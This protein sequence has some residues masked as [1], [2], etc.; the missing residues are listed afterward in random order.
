MQRELEQQQERLRE[1]QEVNKRQSVVSKEQH[2]TLCKLEQEIGQ[3]QAASQQQH[4]RLCEL[5]E[6]IAG[7][8]LASEPQQG[9]LL[10]LEEENRQQRVMIA[11]QQRASKPK[12]HQ[13]QQVTGAVRK[14]LGPVT[15]AQQGAR[16]RKGGVWGCTQSSLVLSTGACQSQT[17]MTATDSGSGG[18]S[19]QTKAV[20]RSVGEALTARDAGGGDGDCSGDDCSIYEL[21]ADEA[22]ISRG[23]MEGKSNDHE[24]S[25]N[26]ADDGSSSGPDASDSTYVCSNNGEH[27]E[28]SCDERLVA[29]GSSDAV[30]DASDSDGSSNCRPARKAARIAALGVQLRRG[31]GRKGKGRAKR[32]RPKQQRKLCPHG[33]HHYYCND[34]GGAGICEHGRRHRTCKDCVGSGICEHR[35]ER[36]YC[37]DC[38][39]IT[40]AAL[41]AGFAFE[42][43]ND[44][45]VYWKGS[46][47]ASGKGMAFLSPRFV[48]DTF[49]GELTAT[50]LHVENRHKPG[51]PLGFKASAAVV[52]EDDWLST[53]AETDDDWLSTGAQTDVKAA[54]SR[55]RAIWKEDFA[56]PV[57]DAAAARVRVTLR[58]VNWLPDFTGRK[59]IATLTLP[60]REVLPGVAGRDGGSGANGLHSTGDGSKLS[61]DGNG[62][63]GGGGSGCGAAATADGRDAALGGSD[64]GDGG[65][66]EGRL[67]QWAGWVDFETVPPRRGRSSYRA[68]VQLVYV[69]AAARVACAPALGGGPRGSTPGMDWRMVAHQVARLP[70]ARAMEP[71]ALITDESTNAQCVVWHD[72][73]RRRLVAA[74]RGTAYLADAVTDAAFVQVPLSADVVPR[75]AAWARFAAALARSRL[76]AA[77]D[78]LRSQRAALRALGTGPTSAARRAYI[79]LGDV[80]KAAAA[81]L[82]AL[83]AAADKAAAAAATTAAAEAGDAAGEGA[84]AVAA[85]AGPRGDGGAS[86]GSGD[87]GADGGGD[88]HDEAPP[89]PP[90][91]VEEAE[92]QLAASTNADSAAVIH[93]GALA[94]PPVDP[95]RPPPPSSTVLNV[96]G[97]AVR[98][99]AGLTQNAL[100]S[101]GGALLNAS[102][103]SPSGVGG[104]SGGARSGGGGGG[105]G[106][107]S[108]GGRWGGVKDDSPE[109]RATRLR[110]ALLEV[111]DVA[112]LSD[113]LLVH[114]GFHKSYMGI[115]AALADVLATVLRGSG[116]DVTEATH[117]YF[118]GHSLGGALATLAALDAARNG[119]RGRA[120]KGITRAMRSTPSV[121]VCAPRRIVSTRRVASPCAV[122]FSAAM[123]SR[124]WPGKLMYNFGSPRVGNN[125][126]SALYNSLNGDSFRLALEFDVIANLPPRVVVGSFT[127]YEHVGRTVLLNHQG[128]RGVRWVEGESEGEDPVRRQQERGAAV[129]ESRRAALSF[130]AGG[131]LV[132][133]H[134]EVDRKRR[135]MVLSVACDAASAAVGAAAVDR[136]PAGTKQSYFIAMCDA[137]G[138]PLPDFLEERRT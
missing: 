77:A 37:K 136:H 114:T 133:R 8:R 137:L 21:E 128:Q 100:R 50:V 70:A 65:A 9:R 121:P 102:A 107:S 78:I 3:Q 113:E 1:L 99:G 130:T 6:E 25:K 14:A 116:E 120:P 64:S 36:R 92:Q 24:A 69:P 23:L 86:R 20:T 15:S 30:S 84:D 108:S 53:S 18:G 17:S 45:T 125:A 4:A 93:S 135:G 79:D 61:S 80:A 54:G 97:G 132:G 58:R 127:E 11:D 112:S 67:L 118:T 41:A 63:A 28:S 104:S 49:T 111:I 129:F 66:G 87:G 91:H 32:P 2:S 57:V 90:P 131:G 59:A 16:K 98:K 115:R 76:A 82:A 42:S 46:H 40:T 51:A 138:R 88:A 31:T 39:D 124:V 7:Q 101:A 48:R 5:Q 94:V 106:D 126:F 122:S 12:Q 89:P 74:F 123:T 26:D 47:T 55:F 85:A 103:A 81:A 119:I 68:L 95:S 72:A 117:V 134:R 22:D 60:L 83:R 62:S 109:R 96:V 27:A 73:P 71:I 34:C 33:R 43:Y 56:M 105:G 44:P 52:L 35:R 13:Q 29:D 19:A 75:D 10:E 110:A 38:G